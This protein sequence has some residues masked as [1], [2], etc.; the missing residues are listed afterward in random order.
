MRHV[1]IIFIALAL[2]STAHAQSMTVYTVTWHIDKIKI[3][4]NDSLQN[5]S[6]KIITYGDDKIMWLQNAD[7]YHTE[8]SVNSVE[9]N[10]TD[11]SQNGSIV[12]HVAFAT[13][14]GTVEFSK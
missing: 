6:C 14:N 7:S 11:V 13:K 3:L 1:F 10:W 2:F 4:D 12:F 9:G 8:F 5:Y